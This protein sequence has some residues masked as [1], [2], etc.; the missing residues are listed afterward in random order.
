MSGVKGL[1]LAA[2]LGTR[3]RPLSTLYPKPLIP[4]LGSSPLEIALGRLSAA[5]LTDAAVNSHYLPDHVASLLERNPFGQ[6]LYQSHEPMLLGTGGVYGPLRGWL[7]ASDLLVCNG[8]I[9]SDFDLIALLAYH[10]TGGFIATM[11]LLP[12]VVAGESAV[13]AKDGRTIAIGRNLPQAQTSGATAHNFACIQVLS[14][15]FLDLLPTSGISDVISQ[16]YQVAFARG[17]PVGGFVQSGMWHDIRDPQFYWLAVKDVMAR[18]GLRN[19]IARGAA[20]ATG[21]R[22]GAAVVVEH[23]ARV[24]RGAQIE[25][26]VIFP[27]AVV[28]EGQIVR[29]QIVLPAPHPAITLNEG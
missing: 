25:N 1:V 5:G 18:R 24:D 20:V 6:R 10:R 8:D 28:G 13:Y 26:A 29:N 15:A 27:G 4:F 19:F 21:A 17:L 2:G 22:I 23:G 7:G 14:P 9:V 12:A 16:A 3:L 11:G